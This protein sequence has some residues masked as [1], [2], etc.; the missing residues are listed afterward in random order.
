MELLLLLLRPPRPV[1]PLTP[2][3]SCV[4]SENL[5]STWFLS[6]SPSLFGPLSSLQSISWFIQCYSRTENC[7]DS[8]QHH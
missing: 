4:S 8:L 6:A 1:I 2:M 7:N 5:I 3:P